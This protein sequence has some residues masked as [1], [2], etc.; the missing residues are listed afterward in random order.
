MK[1]STILFA[2]VIFVAMS[3]PLWGQ[4]MEYVGSTLFAGT[5]RSVEISNGYAY[6]AGDHSLQ[7]F[8]TSDPENPS[9]A[10]G[11]RFLSEVEY[12]FVHDDFAY[13]IGDSADIHIIEV[14]DPA[15][16]I[17]LNPINIDCPTWIHFEGNLAH[18]ST[19]STGIYIYDI[20]DPANP[21]MEGQYLEDWGGFSQIFVRDHFAYLSYASEFIIIDISDWDNPSFAGSYEAPARITE[22]QVIESYC[23]ILWF[24]WEI[25]SGI[26]IIDIS[27]LYNPFMI[28]SISVN[29]AN[30]F[31]VIGNYAYILGNILEI[32][33]ISDRSSPILIGTFPARDFWITVNSDYAYI[34]GISFGILDVSDPYNPVRQ[35]NYHLPGHVADVFVV[36]DYAYTAN[37]I[38]DI[39]V[40]DIEDPENA[41]PV[42][43]YESFG[44]F[45]DVFVS[46]PYA[47]YLARPFQ[48][49]IFDIS[50]PYNP[51]LL[52][53]EF[54]LI[55]PDEVYVKDDRAYIAAGVWGLTIMDVS[56]PGDPFVISTYDDLTNSYEISVVDGYAYIND[57][58][59]V[60]G[61]LK[62]INIENPEDPYLTAVI[63]FPATDIFIHGNYAY[64]SS[65]GPALLIFDITDRSDPIFIGS[66]DGIASAEAVYVSGI[67]AYLISENSIE[68]VDVSNPWNPEGIENYSHLTE[69]SQISVSEDYIFVADRYSL[70]I[71][72]LTQ[73]D[74]DEEGIELPQA[75]SFSQNYPNPFNAA[76]TIRYALPEEAEVSIEIY[77]ILGRRIQT[78][79]A[80]KQ[81]AGTHTVVWEA[82]DVSSGVYFY[83]IEAGEYS[84]T[85]KCV[86]L[87]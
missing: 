4:E 48:F 47:Y 6:C 35:G 62:I 39:Y 18:V 20:S 54:Y 84:Q 83:R 25:G 34:A 82:K 72:R 2:I 24:D 1:R 26:Q 63:D 78:L 5:I 79:V 41:T 23:Y 69:P 64:I 31:S 60:D 29:S 73:T 14:S 77:D 52:S 55:D 87:K 49:K 86:L 51:V 80:G 75:F 59:D 43:R 7:I 44:L 65:T 27:D 11:Y 38:Y 71:L 85:Q 3:A 16:P 67:F 68:L 81:S 56:D 21:L 58:W 50:D 61:D 40:V 74:I 19:C 22:M 57:D 13:V 12:A 76:T 33:D 42:G 8:L 32:F 36:R 30:D 28:G 15:N 70:E 9:L 66:Y 46:Y 45:H 37:F 10:S 53:S 17:A